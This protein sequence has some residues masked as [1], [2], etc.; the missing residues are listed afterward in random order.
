M[1]ADETLTRSFALGIPFRANRSDSDSHKTHPAAKI[2]IAW[3]VADSAR[4]GRDAREILGRNRGIRAHRSWDADVVAE[5]KARCSFAG[6]SFVLRLGSAHVAWSATLAEHHP[7]ARRRDQGQ[8]S[9]AKFLNCCRC[10]LQGELMA[11]VLLTCPAACLLC[12]EVVW[13]LQAACPAASPRLIT[14]EPPPGVFGPGGCWSRAQA[15]AA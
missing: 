10:R 6:R 4:G 3:L 1:L 8:I 13:R 15:L 11:F 2:R 9:K 14:D 7:Y 5:C 12:R